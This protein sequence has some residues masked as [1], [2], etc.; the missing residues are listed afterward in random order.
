MS[1][2]PK[3]LKRKTKTAVAQTKSTKT[4]KRG[5][6][7]LDDILEKYRLS[8]QD[9]GSTDVQIILLSKDIHELV[10]HLQKHKKDFDSKRGLLQMVGRRRRLLNYLR[11][12]DLPKYQ[13]LVIDLG[14]KK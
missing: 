11:K 9:T 12:E 8:K 13:K 10:L 2:K 7:K 14:L 3:I 6:V 1:K 4:I 5:S